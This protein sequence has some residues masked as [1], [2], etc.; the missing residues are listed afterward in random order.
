MR[1][2]RFKVAEPR[3]SICTFRALSTSHGLPAQCASPGRCCVGVSH[4]LQVLISCLKTCLHTERWLIPGLVRV[5]T[6]QSSHSES[7]TS[8]RPSEHDPK[9]HGEEVVRQS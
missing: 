3:F 1:K 2:A 9:V 5:P 7:P 8:P 6:L 4:P